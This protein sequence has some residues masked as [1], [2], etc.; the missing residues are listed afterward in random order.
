MTSHKDEEQKTNI[1]SPEFSEAAAPYQPEE[2]REMSQEYDRYAIGDPF[3]NHRMYTEHDI[4][5][6]DVD[7][8]LRP[9]LEAHGVKLSDYDPYNL[10]YKIGEKIIQ[11]SVKD[12]ERDDEFED[13]VQF[14]GGRF[15]IRKVIFISNRCSIKGTEIL[16]DF[17]KSFQS[18]YKESFFEIVTDEFI[19][20]EELQNFH[21][22]DELMYDPDVMSF[23][24]IED[25]EA[26]LQGLEHGRK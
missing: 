13:S 19:G 26:Y 16:I 12:Y 21:I 24:E 7:R 2:E 15:S 9:I 8:I 10:S 17:L 14:G 1:V 23:L 5:N 11:L 3:E 4:S 6:A 25:K 20:E 18:E 22:D